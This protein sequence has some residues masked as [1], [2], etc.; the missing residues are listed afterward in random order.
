MRLRFHTAGESHGQALA[1]IVEGMPAGVPLD[2]PSIDRD[3]GRRMQGHGR[4][5]RM[6][7][8]RRPDSETQSAG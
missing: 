3:L 1:V 7:I 6:K 5:S 4:G 8:E 2:A